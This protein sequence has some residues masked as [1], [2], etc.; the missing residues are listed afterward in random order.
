VV[1]LIWLKLKM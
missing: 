1:T